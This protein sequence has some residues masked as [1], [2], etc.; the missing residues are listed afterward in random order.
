MGFT[1][2]ANARGRYVAMGTSPIER[3]TAFPFL[4]GR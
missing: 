3:F 4:K 1:I 2:G